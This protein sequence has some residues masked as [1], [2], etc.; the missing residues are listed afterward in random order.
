MFLQE[1]RKDE[2]EVQE[3]QST[4]IRN[5]ID[6]GFEPGSVVEAVRA[7]DWSRLK[8]TGNL[9]VQLQPPGSVPPKEAP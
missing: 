5:L 7:G 4:T 9:S 8:H 1:D 2:A 6:G 3:R